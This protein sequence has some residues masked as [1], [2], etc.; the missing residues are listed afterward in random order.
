MGCGFSSV[1]IR[2]AVTARQNA[3]S[4]DTAVTDSHLTDI[5]G[6]MDMIVFLSIAALGAVGISILVYTVESHLWP[7]NV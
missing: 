5:G 2:L 7:P 4:S 3:V 1:E 6:P